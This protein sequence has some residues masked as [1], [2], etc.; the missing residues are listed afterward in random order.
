ML[1]FSDLK[2]RRGGMRELT[3]YNRRMDSICYHITKDQFHTARHRI[4]ERE[5][6]ETSMNVKK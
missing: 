6:L 5:E 2:V 1:S 4:F 3:L